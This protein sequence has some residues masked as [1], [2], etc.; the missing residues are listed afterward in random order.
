MKITL[1]RSVRVLR[2]PILARLTL[3]KSRQDVVELIRAVQDGKSQMPT[4]LMAYL[5]RE[6]LW[7]GAVKALTEKALRVLETGSM[8][9]RERGLYSIWYSDN[10]PLLGTRPVLIQRNS[11][12][13]EPSW[14]SA[15]KAG[16]GSPFDV[17]EPQLCALWEQRKGDGDQMMPES[18]VRLEAEVLGKSDRAMDLE[19]TWTIEGESADVSL[20][21]MLAV[22]GDAR[23]KDKSR[24]D[25][26]EKISI[27][28][29]WGA[30]R[31]PMLL[32]EIAEALGYRW[33]PVAQRALCDVPADLEQLKNC[34]V[35]LHQF[36]DFL[37]SQNGHFDQVHVERYPLK[38]QGQDVAERWFTHWLEQQFKGSYCSPKRALREQREWLKQPAMNGYPMRALANEELLERLDRH[39]VPDSYW[40]VAAMQDLCPANRNRRRSVITYGSGD[41]FDVAD[42]VQRLTLGQKVRF[43][44]YADRHYKTRRHAGNLKVLQSELQAH[45]GLVLTAADELPDVP[46]GWE[47][48]RVSRQES[49][50][51]RFWLFVTDEANYC[52]TC[53]TSLD[54]FSPRREGSCELRDTVTFTPI[55]TDKIPEFLLRRMPAEQG[56]LA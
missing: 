18:I 21:G 39:R 26:L 49:T 43:C 54:F 52:W 42:L 2:Y 53:T 47:I 11:A 48:F 55:Q 17:D 24:K 30:P 4:R 38:P 33:S 41:V 28:F 44:A 3:R 13:W 22:L 16:V 23:G 25:A 14:D 12:T 40:H 32:S 5:E 50:H 56:A 34:E 8:E 36:A 9:T 19:L 15:S 45:T 20:Q 10:D 6:K 31:V 35:V 1:Q 27:G 46:S 37:S 51:D 29:P 7:D